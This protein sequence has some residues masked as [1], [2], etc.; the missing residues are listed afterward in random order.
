MSFLLTLCYR[1]EID[2]FSLYAIAGFVSCL[3]NDV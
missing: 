2:T 1:T 3:K